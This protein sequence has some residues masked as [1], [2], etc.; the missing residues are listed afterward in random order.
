MNRTRTALVLSIIIIAVLFRFS[1]L[2]DRPMHGDEAI[3]AMK[4]AEVMEAG[5]FDYNPHQ[6]HGPIFYYT[7]ALFAVVRG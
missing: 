4:L 7:S 3:N 6:H 1:Q 5:R 2:S